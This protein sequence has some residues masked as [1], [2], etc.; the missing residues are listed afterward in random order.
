MAALGWTG[1]VGTLVTGHAN[2]AEP[3]VSGAYTG[4]ADD[5]FVFRPAMDGTIGTTPGLTVEVFDQGGQFVAS[6]D[7]GEGYV[8]G[9]ELA[10]ADG[11][12]VAFGLGELSATNNDLFAVELVADSDTSDVLVALGLNG[13]FQGS[14]VNDI[15]VR[16]EIALDPGLIASSIEGAP[17]DGTLLLELLA[18]EESRVS[19]LQGSSLGGFYG[20]IVGDVG[21]QTAT[22]RGALEANGV[23]LQ[24][25]ERRQQ[26]ISGVNVDEELVDLVA[27]EQA[28]AAAA[29]YIS[30]VNELGDELLALI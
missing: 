17:G 21:F 4:D 12:S 2:A 19:G 14:G 28:F 6:L 24:S 3:V 22:T 10:V 29:Q 8:P 11:V 13:F 18:V 1:A 16:S 27:F 5:R 7:V 30:V 20:E 23:L 9:T 26:E 15:E 25:L